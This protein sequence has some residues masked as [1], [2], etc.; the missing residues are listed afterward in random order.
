MNSRATLLLVV[1]AAV[2]GWWVFRT[3]PEGPRP[4]AGKLVFA[5][6]AGPA[7]PLERLLVENRQGRLEFLRSI[8]GDWTLV[9][10]LADRADP[11]TMGE[12]VG[13]LEALPKLEA[14]PSTPERLA[15]CGLREPAVKLSVTRR[16]EPPVVLALGDPTPVEAR[17]YA[18]V[19]GSGE[20]IVIPQALRDLTNR[21]ATAFRDRR[22]SAGDAAKA[23]RVR[24]RNQRGEIELSRESGKWEIVGVGRAN[25]KLVDEWVEKFLG[26]QVRHF[27]G[28]D[29][30]DLLR[31]G[32]AAPR[33]SVRVEFES[34]TGR[35]IAPVEWFL[36]DRAEARVAQGAVYARLP[37]RRAVVALPLDAEDLTHLQPGDFRERTLTALNLD[38]ID[39]VRLEP[40]D[41]PRLLL[42]RRL[43]GWELRE[44]VRRA[45]EAGEMNNLVRALNE[46]EVLDFVSE[47]AE[48]ARLLGTQ[49]ELRLVFA[50]FASETTA[51]S[52]AGET[53][54]V[55]LE[56]SG[57][58]PNG[59]RL[60]RNVEEK[61]VA[62]VRESVVQGLAL[63][64]TEWQQL[65]LADQG[66]GELLSFEARP[67][68]GEPRRFEFRASGG[69]QRTSGPEIPAARVE[70]A[71]ALLRRLRVVRFVPA[72]TPE[73]RLDQPWLVVSARF[74]GRDE[75]LTLRL[76]GKT[77]EGM[78]F[79]Q[80]S[81]RDGVAVLSEPE[82]R[83][84]RGLTE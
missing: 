3:A 37:E 12:F 38:F 70:S 51:E 4:D 72:L 52:A 14:L 49:P 20:I 83:A 62:R 47:E 58:Q 45:A 31:Y 36:G 39:R 68:E 67:A 77:P 50:A 32:L 24:V 42:A 48:A 16:G 84:L 53:P 65:A 41:Q 43:D 30:G 61:L 29:L 54:A 18:Q 82:V 22:L 75:A 40:K 78:W 27:A 64:A 19:S 15:G 56:F 60:V 46:A 55:T 23:V 80:I 10:P 44:P 21:S 73:Q 9:A 25:A 13:M 79:A 71:A 33:G 11:R 69:W 81:G 35:E 1:I 2:A 66:A 8:S 26:Y 7:Q 34:K 57:P 6:A 74:A 17:I 5:Q 63:S 28:P 76:G 59:L